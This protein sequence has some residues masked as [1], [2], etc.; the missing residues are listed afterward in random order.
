MSRREAALLERAKRFDLQALAEIYDRYSP[1]LYRY[2][3]RLLGN[4]DTAEDCVAETFSRFLY[5][6]Q[7]GRGP[8]THLQAYLYR[9]AHNW[10]TDYYRR[11]PPPPLS[12]DLGSHLPADSNPDREAMARIQAEQ[13]RA[14][15]TLLTPD[16]RQVL[17][18]KFFHGW[19][20]EQVAAALGKPIGAVK[21][22]QH[23]A[24]NALRRIFLA[25]EAEEYETIS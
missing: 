12:L 17:V 4:A 20:N 25:P 7:G 2:A 3:M 10:I 15:L 11:Q 22:L 8:D 23:R 14:A 6:L 18:L 24:I 5:V 16:Q 21:S 9:M 13:V 1:G 19:K